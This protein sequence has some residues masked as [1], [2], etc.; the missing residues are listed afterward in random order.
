MNALR[1]LIVAFV[2]AFGATH[3][4]M[5]GDTGTL[6][7]AT[8]ARYHSLIAE[9]RC[10]VCQNRSI[11]E[12]DAPLAAD[13]RDVVQRQILAGQTNTEIKHYLVVRYGDWILYDPP[14]QTSTVLLWGAPFMLLAIGLLIV[15][16][17]MR[18]RPISAKLAT[19]STDTG[20]D[21]DKL[22]QILAED[23]SYE[24]DQ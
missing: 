16:T 6:D 21:S 8:R 10:V 20:S 17:T 11:A 5:A 19:S 7:Q 9:L 22:A 24:R 15:V 2:L 14:I 4:A 1:M 13:L 3:V 12:S 18:R 23:Q